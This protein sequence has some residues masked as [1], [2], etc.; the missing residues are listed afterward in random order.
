MVH[1][2]RLVAIDCGAGR[3]GVQWGEP[4]VALAKKISAGAGLKFSGLQAYQG[5]AQHVH[6]FE[7]RKSQIETATTQV[8]ETVKNVHYIPLL[9][10]VDEADGYEKQCVTAEPGS[11]TSL[12]EQ[13][14]VESP[15][16]TLGFSLIHDQRQIYLRRSKGDKSDVSGV[17]GGKHFR[18][19]SGA[20]EQFSSHQAIPPPGP[21]SSGDAPTTRATAVAAGARK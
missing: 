20:L 14:L 6:D 9:G 21:A 11:A 12:G 13:L 16:H 17:D 19:E 10:I 3:C 1:Q 5:A 4:V 15:E 8:A 2:S 7:V 18:D